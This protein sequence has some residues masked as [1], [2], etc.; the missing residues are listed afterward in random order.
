[1]GCPDRR[2]APTAVPW[3][4]RVVRTVAASLMAGWA[5]VLLMNNP[6]MGE[7]PPLGDF[8]SFYASGQAAMV[9][10]DPYAV[11][12]L[13]MN[14]AVNLNPP[15]SLLVFAPMTAIDPYTLR[16]VWFLATIAAVAATVALLQVRT[17]GRSYRL[18]WAA[19]VGKAR[20]P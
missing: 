14:N 12:E 8:G 18:A 6:F 5:V 2:Y 11:H 10:D 20:K 1:M 9:G 4:W 19:A 7:R 16:R 3:V 17:P 13:T 15:A